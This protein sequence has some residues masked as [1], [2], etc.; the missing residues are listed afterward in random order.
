MQ[1][2]SLIAGCPFVLEHHRKEKL[3]DKVIVRPLTLADISLLIEIDHSYY[4]EYVWQ[5]DLH[6]GEHE[7]SVRF[8]EVRL[9][10]SMRVD[11][12]RDPSKLADDW[13]TRAGVLVAELEGQPAGYLI[14]MQ[15]WIPGLITITDF[16]V[17]PRLRRHG[18]GMILLRASQTWAAERKF[19]RLTLETQSKNYPAICLAKKLGFDFCGYSDKYYPNQ[20]IALFFA[21]RILG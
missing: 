2:L 13:K 4:T 17:V 11:Y 18:I 6:H 5:M 20:D 14:L 1:K 16:A 9:P 15:N 21:K 8:S 19:S 7:S 3:M 10:R 12:P